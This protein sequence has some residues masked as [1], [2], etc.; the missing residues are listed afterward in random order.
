MSV[1]EPVMRVSPRINIDWLL[2]SDQE[3]ILPHRGE[4]AAPTNEDPFIGL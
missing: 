2:M 1:Y 3:K 4:D